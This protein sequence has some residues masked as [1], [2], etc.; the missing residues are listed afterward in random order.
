MS[1]RFLSA[2]L[3]LAILLSLLSGMGANATASLSA[4]ELTPSDK[5]TVN[6]GTS[7]TG[8][9]FSA[10][11]M[12]A[13]AVSAI[14]NTSTYTVKADAVA[15]SIDN[16][17]TEWKYAIFPWFI[18]KQ[19]YV[20]A[21]VD[22]KADGFKAISIN[23]EIN[24][25]ELGWSSDALPA[26]FDMTQSHSI[27]VSVVPGSVTVYVDGSKIVTRAIT[28]MTYFTGVKTGFNV[29]NSV[30][31]FTNI[32][33][34]D[35]YGWKLP[36]SSTYTV[37]SNGNLT[38]STQNAA[39]LA[40]NA[41]KANS[42]SDYVVST[43]IT[44]VQRYVAECKYGIYPWYKDANNWVVFWFDSWEG[45]TPMLTATGRVNGAVVG[46]EWRSAGLP[47]GIDLYG[48]HTFA[49][50]KIGSRFIA[51]VDNIN[52]FDTT[53]DGVS[54]AGDIGLNGFKAKVNYANIAVTDYV[55][56]QHFPTEMWLNMPNNIIVGN[57]IGAG[58]LAGNALYTGSDLTTY[59][60][61]V[62]IK[63]LS[64]TGN[65]RKIGLLPWYKDG[66]NWVCVWFDQW[67]GAGA[68][69]TF[70]GR[71]N[72]T[73][74]NPFFRAVGLPA[75]FSISDEHLLT[76]SK[77]ENRFILKVDGVQYND[78][79]LD[80]VSGTGYVGLNAFGAKAQ[81]RD[82]KTVDANDPTATTAIT[83]VVATSS[84]CE[85]YTAWSSL[86][87]PANVTVKYNND[88][89]TAQIP[90][91]W[92]KPAYF[93]T[94]IHNVLG[95][96]TIGGVLDQSALT[97]VGLNN[98]GSILPEVK[99]TINPDITAPVVTGVQNNHTYYLKN[100]R[101]SI[102]FNEGNGTLNAAVISSGFT[103]D[104]K[105]ASYNLNVTDLSNNT[106]AV[107]FSFIVSGDVNGDGGIDVTDLA[108]VKEHLLKSTPLTGIYATAGD[109]FGKGYISI[110]DLIA[111]KKSIL[112][113]TA[114]N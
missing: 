68:S 48:T 12:N 76:V 33:V 40:A 98:N 78:I 19:N 2:T 23:G 62:N 1:K 36:D 8:D 14:G 43:D 104:N 74:I 29:Y 79:T 113:L 61:S 35:D 37:N 51:F 99:F 4:W 28:G 11:W 103:V 91:V 73:D 7:L 83:S 102:S 75:G 55:G 59:D 86:S 96:Y 30:T 87:L 111:V 27:S 70:V 84:S 26:N 42:L 3:V 38:G 114:L 53:F 89:Q 32:A 13:N 44:L 92:T 58:W 85:R 66:N 31:N 110:S 71:V 6:S 97:A 107:S 46:T 67:V 50:K 95:T 17:K 18:N 54:G 80:G 34:N 65:E 15:T 77:I 20:C 10:V 56:W 64:Y 106:T 82:L 24:H 90:V 9:G 69:L 72:G 39:W 93:D 16:S 63:M 49:I 52:V 109:I 21:W 25:V 81:Y 41:I 45:G 101:P 22:I 108:A 112:G 5:W 57:G 105:T 100:G 47:T 88:S 94:S 60:A